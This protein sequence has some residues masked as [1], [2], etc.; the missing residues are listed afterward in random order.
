MILMDE[1]GNVFDDFIGDVRQDD[2][3][4]KYSPLTHSLVLVRHENSFLFVFDKWKKQ[5]EI[6][7]GKIEPGESFQDCALRELAEESGQEVS[8]LRFRGVTKFILA[9]GQRLEYGVLFCADLGKVKVFKET[10]EIRGI[11]FCGG[12]SPFTDAAEIDLALVKYW[13]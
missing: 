7:G 3:L 1:A 5:W 4:R 8:A 10:P 2:V 6:P 12:R 11:T 13:R 9:P